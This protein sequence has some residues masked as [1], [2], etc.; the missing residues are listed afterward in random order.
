MWNSHCP[1]S[2]LKGKD[3]RMRLKENDFFESEETGLQ[4]AV[5]SGVQAKILNFKA[6]GKF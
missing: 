3:V 6:K 5:L 1:E 2:L 4:L